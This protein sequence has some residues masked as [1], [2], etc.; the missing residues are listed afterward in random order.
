MMPMSNLPARDWSALRSEF[1]VFE[2]T[3]YLK[4]CSLGALSRG[5]RAAVNPFLDLWQAYGASA[6]YRTWLGEI[7]ALRAGFERLV[8]APAGSCTIQHSISAALAVI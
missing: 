2:H 4:T 1:P 6:W 7:A 8:N 5:T 3:T